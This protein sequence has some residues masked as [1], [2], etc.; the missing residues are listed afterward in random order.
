MKPSSKTRKT[1]A[2]KEIS[3]D[4]LA[5]VGQGHSAFQILWAG[6]ELNVFDLLSKS[7]GR[8]KEAQI[9]AKLGLDPIPMRILL[10]GLLTLKLIVR[11]KKTGTFRNAALAEANLTAANPRNLRAVLGW[12]RHIVYPAAG[13]FVESLR[14]NRNIG[15]RHF[16]GEGDTLYSRLASNHPELETCFQNAM[17]SLS[18]SANAH[19]VEYLDL[20]K[21]K[22]LVDIGGGDGTN[23]IAF[24][25]GNPKLKVTVLDIPT[26]CERAKAN[27]LNRGL[28]KRVSTLPGD[29]FATPF[30]PDMDSALY[31][32]IVTIWSPE[33]NIELLRRIYEAL[34]VG[35]KVFILSQ[36]S[37]DDGV[38]PMSA[39]L[40][41]VYFQTVA[42]GKGMMYSTGEV[43]G[44]AQDAGFRIHD[45]GKLPFDHI[46][47]VGI[48]R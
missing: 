29:F 39:A 16:P 43:A 36:L 42:T 9:A 11:D 27:V 3:F 47:I 35:G 31:A 24:A 25:K 44:F 17:R 38:G 12:Q 22:H 48:K 45:I 19:L 4:E 6:V 8:L 13:D 21:Q 46:V 41:S 14:T 40:G 5:L 33:K 1:S 15:L 28:S 37:N 32:H 7:R 20:R 30:P 10:N 23:A 18:T 26:V 34:P 2:A